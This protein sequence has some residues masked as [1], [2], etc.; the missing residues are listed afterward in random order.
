VRTSRRRLLV[1][2]AVVVVVAAAVVVTLVVV[3]RGSGT[4]HLRLK[5]FGPTSSTSPGGAICR[6]GTWPVIFQGRPA[7]LARA[8]GP[9]FFVWNDPSGWH[10][11]AIDAR[12]KDTFI[13]KVDAA[14][15]LDPST[16]EQVPAHS[17]TLRVTDGHAEFDFRGGAV[18]TGIDFTMCQVD[19]ATFTMGTNIWPWPPSGIAIGSSSQAVANPISVARSG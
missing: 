17:G 7:T 4:T 15:R 10:I 2:T 11:R 16:F 18:A 13:I 9:G 8:T 5:S 6:P 1:G 14:E 12:T 19:R 3:R